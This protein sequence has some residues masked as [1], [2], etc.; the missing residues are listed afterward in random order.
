MF[1]KEKIQ[2]IKMGKTILNENDLK[3]AISYKGEIFTLQYPN[4]MLRSVIETEI[5]RRLGGYPR[6]SFSADHIT[7]VEACATIDSL[8]ISNE[9]PDW[10]DGP[11]TCVDD[12]LIATLYNGYL[13]F[14][15]QFRKKL[16]KDKLE[17]DS[18][19]SSP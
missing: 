12:A 8:M 14:R 2:Q 19:G 15:D 5:A 16:R 4:P 6:S 17:G 18:K 3:I 10:F 13:R 1:N 9:C 11:W 7:A